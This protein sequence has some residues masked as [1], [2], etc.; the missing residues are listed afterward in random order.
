[1]THKAYRGEIHQQATSSEHL[2]TRLNTNQQHSSQDF[3]AW[4]MGRLDLK[5]GMKVLDVG[6]GTGNQTIPISRRVGPEGSV[7]ALDISEES[8]KSLLQSVELDNVEAYAADMGNLKSV[9]DGQFKTKQFDLAQSTYALYYADDPESV[10]DVMTQS[11]L[12]NGRLAIFVPD[13]PHGMVSLVGE[14]TAIPEQVMESLTFGRRVL[15]PYFRKTFSDV[16]THLFH[17]T[18]NLP[19]TEAFMSMWKA[20]TYYDLESD[21]KVRTEVS[22]RAESDGHF[23]LKKNGFMIIGKDKV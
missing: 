13:L 3:I 2:Q 4:Q 23:D 11:L 16:T 22:K 8:I 1:M 9:I 17:N 15:E 14:F 18:L 21:E 20:T 10:L 5:P 7:S 12:P 19:D 6:C